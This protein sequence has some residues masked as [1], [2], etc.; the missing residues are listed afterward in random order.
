MF[1]PS[2]Q[3]IERSQLPAMFVSL[4]ILLAVA[5]WTD[6][7]VRKI[8]NWLILTGLVIS[9]SF[10]IVAGSVGLSAWCIGLLIG[11]CA[12]FPMYLMR[13]MG[14][15]DVKLMAMVGAFIGP[16]YAIGAVLATLL[17]GGVLAI[18]FALCHGQLAKTLS[19]VRATMLQVCFSILQRRQPVASVV[20]DTTLQLPYAIAIAS[21]TFFYLVFR[22]MQP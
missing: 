5:I 20:G 14:A 13:A 4:A 9:F 18:G 12:L 2:L 22:V 11:F 16:G 7:Q 15:G 1:E 21:G 10:Q 3:H 6:I 8:P 17:S 19:N